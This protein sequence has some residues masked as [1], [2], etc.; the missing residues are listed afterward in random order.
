TDEDAEAVMAEVQQAQA[1]GVTGVPTF[2]LA[3][4]YGIVGAQSP[5]YIADA[6]RKAAAETT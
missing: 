3:S 2:I 4:R 6:L 1:I 5:Q